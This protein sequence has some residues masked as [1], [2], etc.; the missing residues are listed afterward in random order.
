M[1]VQIITMLIYLAVLVGVV[2]LVIW[3]LGQL[4]IALPP[5]IVKIVYIII[6]LLVLLWFVQSFLGGGLEVPRI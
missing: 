3:V 6:A 2:Y 1:L 5:G 4:G